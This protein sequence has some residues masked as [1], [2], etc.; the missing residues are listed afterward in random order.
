MHQLT[1]IIDEN[2]NRGL[3][4]AAAAWTGGRV[5]AAVAARLPPGP[6]ASASTP[7]ASS[8]ALAAD[9]GAWPPAASVGL[10]TATVPTVLAGQQ[11]VCNYMYICIHL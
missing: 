7:A 9:E 10:Q 2:I 6:P 1:I 3:P 4:Y 5:A 8:A 11:C